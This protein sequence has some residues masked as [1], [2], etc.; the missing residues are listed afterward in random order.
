MNNYESILSKARKLAAII[1][2]DSGATDGERANAQRMLTEHCQRH[3][4]TMEALQESAR[5]PRDLV[6]RGNGCTVGMHKDAFSIA[7][8]CL[9]FVTDDNERH[10][11]IYTNMPAIGYTKL[12]GA[13]KA[14]YPEGTHYVV[15]ASVTP[16]EYEDWKAC[17]LYYIPHFLETE[18]A[19]KK[20]AKLAA[21]RA[22]LAMKAFLN[23]HDIFSSAAKAKGPRKK[24]K[25]EDLILLSQAM[26][27]V[28][29]DTWTKPTAAIESG[30]FLQ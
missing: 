21:K 1:A 7:V 13:R 3:G 22:K 28:Q 26:N 8:A 17:W 27:H 30:F 10:F 2:P 15:R 16:L 5:Q 18:A 14:M 4:I 19:L 24:S 25:L 23:Q 20:E 9:F 12:K 29:G 11:D 6:L